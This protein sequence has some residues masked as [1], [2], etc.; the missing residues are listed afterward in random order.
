MADAGHRQIVKYTFFK[1][2]AEW[3]RLAPSERDT[4]RREFAAAVW[5]ISERMFTRCFSLIG[6]R[7]DADFL[8]WQAADTPEEIQ[9]A[10]AQMCRR[11][12]AA[13]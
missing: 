6:L 7:G 9:D 13:I 12:W 10:A 8:L 4:H 3:R 1:A 11:G 5:D 2:A